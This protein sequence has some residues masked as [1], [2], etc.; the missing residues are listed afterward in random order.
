MTIFDDNFD[1]FPNRFF[2]KSWAV[3]LARDRQ[4]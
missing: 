1:V 3:F 4:Q 2:S